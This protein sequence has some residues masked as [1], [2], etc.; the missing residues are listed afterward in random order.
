MELSNLSFEFN[1]DGSTQITFTINA[2][3]EGSPLYASGQALSLDPAILPDLPESLVAYIEQAATELTRPELAVEKVLRSLAYRARSAAELSDFVVRVGVPPNELVALREELNQVRAA[4]SER[5]GVPLP[6]VELTRDPWL[7]PW[8]YC[9]E[10]LGSRLAR[11]HRN[12]LVEDLAFCFQQLAPLMLSEQMTAELVRGLRRRHPDLVKQ[13][14]ELD[15]PLVHAVLQDILAKGGSI[16]ELPTVLE[17]VLRNIRLTEDVVE[18]SQYAQLD[19]TWCR[20]MD[21]SSNS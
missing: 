15:L 12:E 17:S 11:G 4:T 20:S 18:L 7:A 1:E 10:F 2:D 5:L 13:I 3:L 14:W 16:R 21:E 8:Q 6:L 19:L 9:V